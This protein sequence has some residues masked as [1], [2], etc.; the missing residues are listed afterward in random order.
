M[1]HGNRCPRESRRSA[2]RRAPG[3]AMRAR[4]LRWLA[5]AWLA[6][7]AGTPWALPGTFAIEQ[8]FSSADGVVQ[9]VVVRDNGSN[10][11][12]AGEQLWTGQTLVSTGPAGTRTF[13]FPA[14]LPTCKTSKM[15]ILIAT[16]GFAALGLVA[17]DFLIPNGFVQIPSGTVDF[18]GLSAVTYTSMPSDGVTAID[19]SARP[20]P[21]LATNLAGASTSVVL[22]ANV[23]TVVEYFHAGLD[24][25]FITWLAAEIAILDAGVQIKGWTR[26]GTTFR[27][28]TTAQAGS[29][30][31]CR[32]Y[33]PPELGDSHFFGRGTAECESTAKNFPALMLEDP[34]F[35]HMV[36][37]VNGM[38]PAG[39]GR[40]FRVFSNR[41]DANHR[42][43]T[44]PAVRDQMTA[45]GW[46]AEGDGPDLVVMCAP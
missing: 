39:T 45:K 24:H 25:Y 17:P 4:S 3:N 30:P 16:E 22:A 42:Y 18:A 27:T 23:A 32:F 8:I 2:D 29:S 36:L 20:V 15:R 26:T 37:P 31:V 34:A 44:D 9:F 40:I 33:I 38:C 12:D 28:Y 5:A 11:C 14:N 1:D 35:M 6:A 41:A 13:T 7:A 21:N 19:A 10:D 46:L 43:M